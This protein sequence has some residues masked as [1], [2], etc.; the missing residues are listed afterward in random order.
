MT[1]RFVAVDEAGL[2]SSPAEVTVIQSGVEPLRGTLHAVSVGVGR[3]RE[4]ELRLVRSDMRFRIDELFNA[5]S[6]VIAF[7][8][9][10]VHLYAKTPIEVVRRE[11]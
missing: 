3:Y 11:D 10:D 8:Q 2:R 1:L 9:R 4:R 7:P 5:N 6:I